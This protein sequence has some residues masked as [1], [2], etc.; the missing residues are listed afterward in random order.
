M[1]FTV[2][3][4]VELAPDEIFDE[5]MQIEK[6][7]PSERTDKDY[8][9]LSNKLWGL[10]SPPRNEDSK[11]KFLKKLKDLYVQL[12]KESQSI[13]NKCPDLVDKDEKAIRATLF[14]FERVE[15]YLLTISD[16][17]KIEYLGKIRDDFSAF[18]ESVNK[19][20]SYIRV[21]RGVIYQDGKKVFKHSEDFLKN[22][23]KKLD[24]LKLIEENKFAKSMV[25]MVH[26]VQNSGK[27]QSRNEET[28]NEKYSQIQIILAFN[29]L[30][31]MLNSEANNTQKAQLMS[32]F[33]RFSSER[34][35]QKLSSI[36]SSPTKK[37]IESAIS[38]FLKNGF[39]ELAEAI[40][41]EYKSILQNKT[42]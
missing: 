15:K 2:E 41:K 34:L 33:T 28:T 35:R 38:F 37:D 9:E 22:I 8:S 3:E 40:E 27:D 5:F 4:W 36:H 21:S 32:F 11:S 20:K 24:E 16:D 14:L 19:H 12:E 6:T 25:S 13:F 1:V 23:N 10:F 7:L 42:N 18:S 17:E 29:C 30:F 39:S 31:K 26:L